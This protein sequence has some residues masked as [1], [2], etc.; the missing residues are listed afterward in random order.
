MTLT[1]LLEVNFLNFYISET[2]RVSICGR[3]LH[4]FLHLSSSGVIKKIA[5]REIDLFF[6][7]Q[8]LTNVI[9]SK[10]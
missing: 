4:I 5:L 8:E 9:S 1:Y 6:E 2:V 7:G 10:W 3:H